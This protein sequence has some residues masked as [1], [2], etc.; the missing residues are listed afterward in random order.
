MET[1]LTLQKNSAEVISN[2][3]VSDNM[4]ISVLKHLGLPTEKIFATMKERGKAIKNFPEIIEDIENIEDAYYL[5]KFLVAVSSGMF[6]AAL[7]Y[8]WDETIK[9]LRIRVE[10]ID[11]QYFY[12]VVIPDS[13]R[14]DFSEAK[15]LLKLDDATLI[16]GAKKVGLIE[17]IGYKHLDYIRSMRNMASAAHPN[18]VELTGLKLVS[19]LETCINEV[20][21]TPIVKGQ[22]QI[23]RLLK[24]IKEQ[25]LSRQAA[26][27]MESNFKDLSTEKCN[28]FAKGLFGI[29]IDI[30]SSPQTIANINLVV[31]YLWP[32]ITED[33]RADFGVRCAVFTANGEMYAKNKSNEFLDLVDG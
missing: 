22:I 3:E 12:N 20:I 5:S 7:S 26:Q 13:K 24:N 25:E 21:A 29:Y 11:L 32:F 31:P 27:V 15:D 6:D 14:K 1:G 18:Q 9:Q 4:Y 30:K 8:L 33:V 2:I 16:E 17:E 28:T 10:A 19:W 23:N